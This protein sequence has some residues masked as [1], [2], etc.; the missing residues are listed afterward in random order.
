MARDNR[1]GPATAMLRA[2]PAE[3]RAG[4]APLEMAATMKNDASALGA[5]IT[6][7]LASGNPAGEC[8]T[9][10]TVSELVDGSITGA[11][12]DRLL[13]HLAICDNCRELFM[14]SSG[15]ACEQPVADQQTS[16]RRRNYLLPSA[17]AAA[18]LLIIGLTL[19]LSPLDPDKGTIAEIAGADAP[20]AALPE[21]SAVNPPL[22]EGE[23]R[24]AK[25]KQA[26]VAAGKKTAVAREAS[27]SDGKGLAR[28]LVQHGNPGQLASLAAAQ[29]RSFAFAVKADAGKLAFRIGV[30]LMN[31]EVALLADDG[32]RA[33]AQATR[34]S[35]LLEMLAG[36]P[37]AAELEGMVERLE[38]GESPSSVA[39]RSGELERLVPEDQLPFA[40]LGA[41]AQGAKLAARTGNR[42]YLAAGVPRYFAGRVADASFPSPAA[43]A[44][45]ELDD[46]LKKPRSVDLELVEKNL[47]VLL[48]AF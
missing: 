23:V 3:I 9:L 42:Q 1:Y 30:N 25:S 26:P 2:T 22:L 29:D 36:T 24:V 12:R 45:R 6:R 4:L 7:G 16:C 19:Q 47:A 21:K 33:Q 13:G 31:L 18:A 5:A 39:G 43:S 15:L 8:P 37:G 27:P 44:L 46:Q 34:L 41:W 11:G 32:D 28:L 10:E 14:V 35:P 38:R 17:L 40:R 20:R 48:E